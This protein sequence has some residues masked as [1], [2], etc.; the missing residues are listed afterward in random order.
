[1]IPEIGH[2]ALTLALG[3]AIIQAV[4]PLAGAVLGR[5]AWLAVARPAAAGQMA[6]VTIAL[7]ALSWSFYANDFSVAYVA[8]NSNTELPW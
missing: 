1:M 5:P 3:M 8:H 2:F 4:L 7:L 6:F